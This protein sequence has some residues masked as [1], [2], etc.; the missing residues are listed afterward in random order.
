M[1]DIRLRLMID[2]LPGIRSTA[3]A[4]A[5]E[6]TRLDVIG[7]NIANLNTTR[8]LDGGPYRRQQV[9]FESVLDDRIGRPDNLPL[10][11]IRVSQIQKDLR[12]P[13]MVYEP[14][15]P[16]ANAQGMVAMPDIN[17]YEEMVDLIA[18]SRSFEANLAVMKSARTL[19]MQELA[20]GRR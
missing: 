15:H 5:A 3:S 20:I 8:G 19:A 4:L 17:L 13:K 14:G 18:A 16:D 2:L 6:R 1:S 10:Q 11:S 9:V 12:P 7:Q